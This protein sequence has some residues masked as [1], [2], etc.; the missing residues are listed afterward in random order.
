MGGIP[1]YLGLSWFLIA[2]VLMATLGPSIGRI[3]PGIGWGAYG[4]AL[5]YSLLLL[6]SVFVHEFAHAWMAARFGYRVERVVADLF[7]GH[8]VYQAPDPSPGRMAAVAFVGPLSNAVLALLGSLLFLVVTDPLAVVLVGAITWTNAFVA[9]FNLLPGIPLDGGHVVAAAVWKLTGDRHTGTFAAALLGC[10]L[11]IAGAAWFV[12]G[13]WSGVLVLGPIN[14]ILLLLLAVY[15]W[16]GSWQSL[17]STRLMRRLDRVD[18][19]SLLH[20]VRV[21]PS[22]A[23]LEDM[24]EAR[25]D[26]AERLP[27]VILVVE[28]AAPGLPLG[29]LDPE[30]VEAAWQ[31]GGHHAPASSCMRTAPEGWVVEVE[32]QS[33]TAEYVVQMMNE[34][35]SP[36][37]ALCDGQGPYAVAEAGLLADA[38]DR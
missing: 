33:L 37:L 18:L 6:L 3:V 22:D 9:A 20:P 24:P 16:Q 38:L 32:R 30:A 13:W 23:P 29:Y 11:V 1:V 26:A 14:L 12:Y 36:V 35:E 21:M 28:R 2:A 27:A 5:L 25:P 10:G 19:G 17:R 7:G 15:L 31:A 34:R 4:A 8:T